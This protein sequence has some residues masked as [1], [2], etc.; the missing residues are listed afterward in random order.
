MRGF[1]ECYNDLKRK[2]FIARLVELDN[3]ISK[4]KL[5]YQLAAPRDNRLMLVERAIQMLKNHFIAVRNGTDPAFPT[6]VWSHI[7]EH[8]VVTLNMLL[9]TR[10]N[11]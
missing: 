8:V 1:E 10:L 4:N 2:E 5:D 7:L 9:P 6:R 11:S 3:E